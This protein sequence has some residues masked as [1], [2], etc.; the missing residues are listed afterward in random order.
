M[1][2][3]ITEEA[4]H[5]A[6]EWMADKNDRSIDGVTV[7]SNYKAW[8]KCK[9][10][11]H[12][13]QK[14]V[15]YRVKGLGCQKCGRKKKGL[16]VDKSPHLVEEW[17]T[18]KNDRPIDEITIGARYKAWWQCKTCDNQWQALVH[19][20]TTGAGCRPCSELQR[21]KQPY[22]INAFQYLATE[23]MGDKNDRPIDGVTGGSNYKAWWQCKKCSHEWQA[24]VHSRI[25]R[26]TGCPKC[27]GKDKGL[28][29]DK[30]PHLVEEWVTEKNDRPINEITIGSDYKAW[31][32]CKKCSLEWHASVIKRARN[33]SGCP[34]CNRKK[35]V[36]QE[37]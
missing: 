22:I 19:S 35:K 7:G 36:Y 2:Q 8:W 18:E 11:S 1:K 23:W 29:V 10:C 32:K 14:P 3:K 6:S 4:S 20:R 34:K 21:K 33:N 26:K 15:F 37:N 13:W 12:E 17:V 27:A 5:L 25:D 28:L 24:Q 31:W 30:S 16:L 9:T